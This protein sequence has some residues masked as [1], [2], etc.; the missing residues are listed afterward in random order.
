MSNLPEKINRLHHDM[1]E[2]WR[3]DNQEQFEDGFNLVCDVANNP[4]KY[5]LTK[6][7]IVNDGHLLT[8]NMSWFNPINKLTGRIPK[9]PIIGLFI[10]GIRPKEI[11]EGKF[12]AGSEYAAV[13]LTQTFA[14]MGYYVYIFSFKD[15]VPE[16]DWEYTL[17]CRNPQI[18]PVRRQFESAMS[19][20]LRAGS[21]VSFSTLLQKCLE[22]DKFK[23]DHLI[24]SREY[25]REGYKFT[26]YA[27][28][29]HLWVHDFI[30]P[31][32]KLTYQPY[33][34]YALTNFH[35]AQIRENL[36]VKH[37]QKFIIGNNGTGLTEETMTELFKRKKTPRRCVYISSYSRG[38]DDLLDL[39]PTFKKSF[40]DATL[41][42][43]YGRDT[44]GILNQDQLN[45]IV[46][47][48]ERTK[49]LDVEECGRIPHSQLIEEL[50]TASLLLYPYKTFSETFF[51]GG[52]IAQQVGCIP[53]V[54]KK[55]ALKE[56][57]YPEHPYVENLSQFSEY[58][59]AM[60]E[61]DVSS[62]ALDE[63]REMCFL[64]AKK[65]TWENAAKKW[66]LS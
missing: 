59:H 4:E 39:W 32:D 36:N 30:L 29:V 5:S 58:A 21:I 61:A 52:A 22:S 12:G 43:Y 35:A 54:I 44:W 57:I 41:Q 40:P 49:E 65:Y 63:V 34:V 7:H 8:A 1:A 33:S 31:Q 28:K 14:Q 37:N 46:Q 27:K 10:N 19:G 51:I 17:P 2:A 24:V 26:N 16:N 11:M 9:R 25:H 45:S 6:E 56:T 23:L 18:L 62:D 3:S 48:I 13:Q 66:Q 55:H 15:F 60:L 47:K 42:I 64:H 38:L 53:V 50:S 20:Q